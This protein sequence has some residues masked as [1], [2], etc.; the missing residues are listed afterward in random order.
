MIVCMYRGACVHVRLCV[1]MCVCVRVC[2]CVCVYVIVYTY[3]YAYLLSYTSIQMTSRPRE[4][5]GE[6]ESARKKKRE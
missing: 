4:S 5:K 3:V 1:C 2:V 6:T